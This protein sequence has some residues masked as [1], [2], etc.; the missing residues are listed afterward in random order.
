MRLIELPDDGQEYAIRIHGVN[1]IIQE[2]RVEIHT[3]E[4]TELKWKYKKGW[5]LVPI[6]WVDPKTY[7]TIRLTGDVGEQ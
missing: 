5:G 3:A 6:H 7:I 4:P 2:T 1:Y